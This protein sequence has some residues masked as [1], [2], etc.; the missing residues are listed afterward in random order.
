MTSP[1]QA[2]ALTTLAGVSPRLRHGVF[3]L[4]ALLA[5]GNAVGTALSPYL[6][7]R[8]PLFLV[9]ISPEGRHVVLAT[10]GV[11]PVLLVVVGTL[12]RL[13]GIVAGYGLGSM[14]GEAAVRWA[15]QRV[16]RFAR[17][18]R[19]LERAFARFGMVMVFVVP[20]PSIGV[21]AGASRARFRWVVLAGALGQAT[22]M[23]LTV[24]FGEAIAN[25]TQPVLAFFSRHLVESTI[26]AAALV[27][28]Q[29]LVAYQKRRR[30]RPP[31]APA[32]G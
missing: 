16:P 2:S 21:L 19:F 3:A 12:R 18:I 14:Y 11:A 6:V 23:T 22:W 10:A 24:L 9:A 20:L 17:I 7:V 8:H 25:W 28:L 15:E 30:A 27:G 5:I 4:I 13:L 31:E 32:D 29:Q 26:V 1:A